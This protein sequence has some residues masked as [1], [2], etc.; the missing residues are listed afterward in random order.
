VQTGHGCHQL[1]PKHSIRYIPIRLSAAYLP[2]FWTFT[3][4]RWCSVTTTGVNTIA[5]IWWRIA[6]PTWSPGRNWPPHSGLAQLVG[7]TFSLHLLLPL[8][9]TAEYAEC[10]RLGLH[11]FC[12]SFSWV[13]GVGLRVDHL[14]V[15]CYYF[16]NFD[17]LLFLNLP[18]VVRGGR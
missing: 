11:A 14:K 4:Y 15:I 6:L 10:A 18:S 2:T 13:D 16:G 1:R 5:Q 17:L 8:A 7:H 3:R 9:P 12:H